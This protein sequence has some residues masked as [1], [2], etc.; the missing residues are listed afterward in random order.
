V[1]YQ[2]NLRKIIKFRKFRVTFWLQKSFYYIG[3]RHSDRKDRAIIGTCAAG[4]EI[5]RNA[6]NK[7]R[8]IK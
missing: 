5:I 8:N 1:Q 2:Q 6:E 3:V 7:E 4:T